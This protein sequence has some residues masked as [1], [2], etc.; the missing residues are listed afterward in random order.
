[1]QTARALDHVPSSTGA[2]A[3]FMCLCIACLLQ[4]TV[5]FS[6]FWTL[7]LLYA[8]ASPPQP[9]QDPSNTRVFEAHW[10]VFL[11]VHSLSGSLEPWPRVMRVALGSRMGF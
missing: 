3:V 10:S 1:M 6:E 7:L 4:F 8:P 11:T 5:M 9:N 2:E